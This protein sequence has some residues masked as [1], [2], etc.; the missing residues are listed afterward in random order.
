MDTPLTRRTVETYL[1]VLRAIYASIEVSVTTASRLENRDDLYFFYLGKEFGTSNILHTTYLL[2]LWL[3]DSRDFEM[4]PMMFHKKNRK[5]KWVD[6]IKLLDEKITEYH[7]GVPI[8][9]VG[10][11]RNGRVVRE[12]MGQK[13]IHDF[14]SDGLKRKVVSYLAG[15]GSFTKTPEIQK[16]IGSKSTESAVKAI[17]SINSTLRLRLQFPKKQKF[18]DSKRGSGYGINPIY[19][20]VLLD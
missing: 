6:L 18:I 20:V 8:I 9:E 17:R 19:N 3:K 15:R 4:R 2:K 7:D 1:P 11:H 10:I 16:Y 12:F 5:A 13:L 14:G